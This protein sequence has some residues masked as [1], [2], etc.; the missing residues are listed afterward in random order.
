MLGV[1]LVTAVLAAGATPAG[2][3]AAADAAKPAAQISVQTPG[4]DPAK[5]ADPN[6]LVCHSEQ[7]PGSR[8]TTRTCMHVE[9]WRMRQLQDRQNL[10]NAQGRSQPSATTMMGPS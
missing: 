10:N 8:L 4:K 9:E 1:F 7:M 3:Q 2:A 6:A 5:P